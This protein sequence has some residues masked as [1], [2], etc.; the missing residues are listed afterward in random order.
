MIIGNGDIGSVLIDNPDIT[1]FCSGVSNSSCTD[2]AEFERERM[3]LLT[4]IDAKHLVYISTLAIYYGNSMYVEHKRVMENLIRNSFPSYTIIR[5]GNITWGSNPHTLINYLNAHPDA[6]V[7]PVWRYLLD[8]Q[9]FLHWVSMARVGYKE[10][11]NITGRMVWVPELAASLK[12]AK[13]K[14]IYAHGTVQL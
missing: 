5:I 9:E 1:Y 3:L 6:E 7:Q 8:L 4:H 13:V 10:E 14:K 12:A 11:M 2:L